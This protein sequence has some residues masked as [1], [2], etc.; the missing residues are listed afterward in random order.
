MTISEKFQF[1]QS[2]AN[3]FI[4]MGTDAGV[5]FDEKQFNISKQQSLKILK[6]L[7]AI[8]LWQTTEYFRIINDD[9]VVLKK[10]LDIL[11][12]DKAYKKALGY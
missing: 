9:D 4:K 2:D 8:D 11:A 10:A 1:K 7:V 12:D 6:A 3:A 5:K